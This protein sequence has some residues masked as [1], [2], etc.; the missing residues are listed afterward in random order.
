LLAGERAIKR[1]GSGQGSAKRAQGQPPQRDARSAQGVLVPASRASRGPLKRAGAPGP[2]ASPRSKSLGRAAAQEFAFVKDTP[3]APA[4][5]R[6]ARPAG[7]VDL[8]SAVSGTVE[9]LGYDCVDVERFGRNQLRVTIDRLPGR[10]YVDPGMAVTVEDCEAVSRQL[11]YAL[12][13]DGLDYSRLEVSSP[14]LDRPLRRE[15]DYARFCGQSVVITLREPFNGRKKYQGL[16]GAAVPK[17]SGWQLLLD[18]T[19]P[20]PTGPL[21]A[22]GLPAKPTKAATAAKATAQALATAARAKAKRAAAKDEQAEQVLTFQLAEVRDARLV[23]V[24]N[25][26][27]RQAAGAVQ[28]SPDSGPHVVEVAVGSGVAVVG[29][30]G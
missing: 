2:D 16:L 14:G 24:L 25:F 21:L 27:G 10:R 22:G 5:V 6:P 4:V 19:Q 3:A 20:G 7:P 29:G 13:V 26:K 8:R 23:P 18:A 28:S 17:G 9:G 12:E 15:A 11:Q 1:S 30:N